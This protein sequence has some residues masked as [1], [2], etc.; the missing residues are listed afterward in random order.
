MD[1]DEEER[2]EV[3]SERRGG[4]WR[5]SRRS[6]CA[7][8]LHWRSR[9]VNLLHDAAFECFELQNALELHEVC[10]VR[11]RSTSRVAALLDGGFLGA[12]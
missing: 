12:V 8:L 7:F 6:N 3:E 10:C 11:R 1:K 5:I 4:P 9:S 2:G